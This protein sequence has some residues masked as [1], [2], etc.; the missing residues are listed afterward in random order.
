MKALLITVYVVGMAVFIGSI[1]LQAFR[2]FRQR[3]EQS[4][5]PQE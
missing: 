1:A 2:F 4:A 3:R 5:S